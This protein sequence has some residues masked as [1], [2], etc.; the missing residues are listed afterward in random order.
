MSLSAYVPA[1]SNYLRS[2]YAESLVE[3]LFIGSLQRHFW[4][5]G[6]VEVLKPEV[7]VTGYDLVLEYGGVIRYVQMKNTCEKGK[8]VF[9]RLNV[10]LAEKP[11]GCVIVVAHDP[12]FDPGSFRYGWFG[13]LP[14][15]PLPEEW[16]D[17]KKARHPK[18]DS[19]GVK[20]EQPN[21]RKLPYRK[22]K[23]GLTLDELAER[24]FG[25][26]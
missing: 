25:K 14:G 10:H 1:E 16:K 8:M 13:S 23:R 20:K 26:R 21:I 11:S 19:K 24:L 3:H 7:D 6:V 22:F 12:T 4:D 2:R 5:R 15:Q 9:V 17:L 18:G